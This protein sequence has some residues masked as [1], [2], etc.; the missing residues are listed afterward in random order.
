MLKNKRK[1]E[2]DENTINIE[3]TNKSTATD[4]IKTKKKGKYKNYSTSIVI[5]SSVV[6]NAQVII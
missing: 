3:D 5:P 6:D 2:L 1:R 4:E